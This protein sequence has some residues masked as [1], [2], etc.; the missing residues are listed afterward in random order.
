M[1]GTSLYERLG[2][3]AAVSAAVV[4]LHDRLARSPALLSFFRGVEMRD[5]LQ[6]HIS[7]VMTAFGRAPEG[8]PRDLRSAHARL[9][10]EGLGDAHFDAIVAAMAEVL[11]ELGVEGTDR[12]QVLDH[13]ESTRVEVLGR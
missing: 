7:F 9:V 3:E 6:V 5:R 11:D 8:R 1:T 4:L 13:I 12:D 10:A 2:G